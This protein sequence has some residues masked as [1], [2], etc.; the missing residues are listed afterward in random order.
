MCF[1]KKAFDIN[2]MGKIRNNVNPL[3]WIGSL[4][5][6]QGLPYV[7][8][9]T[10]SVIMYKRLGLSNT[11]I[12]FYTSWLYLPWVIKPLWSP[13]VELCSS[14]RIWIL[15]MQLIIGAA[16]ASI[17]LSLHTNNFFKWS[18]IIFWLIAF[19]SA[20]HDI[21]ADGF[22]ILALDSHKQALFVGLRSTF[23]RLSMIAGQGLLVM[24]A[25]YFE[26]NFG[27]G[28]F[29][30]TVESEKPKLS[31]IE[32]EKDSTFFLS[33]PN[34]TLDRSTDKINFTFFP[35]AKISIPNI[36]IP[37]KKFS[38]ILDEVKKFNSSESANSSHHNLIKEKKEN[39]LKTFIESF[40]KKFF[41]EKKRDIIKDTDNDLIGNVGVLFVTLNSKLDGEKKIVVNFD[42]KS[43]D[44]SIRLI[45]GQRHEFTSQNY[46]KPHVLL[47]QLDPN[48]KGATSA[49]FSLRFGNIKFAWTIIFIILSILFLLFFIYHFFLLPRPLNDISS[50]IS[51]SKI[52]S[53]FFSPFLSF[54]KKDN[55]LP[56]IAFLLLYRLGESQLVKLASPFLLDTKTSGGLSLSTGTLG[57]VYGTMGVFLLTVGGILGGIVV[58]RSGLK[59]W[60]FPM[61]IAINLPNI[62]YVYMAYYQPENVALI[63]AL[64]GIEQF[65][66]GFGFAAYMLFMVYYA[67]NSDFKTSHYAIMTGFMALGMMLPGM[68][69]GWLQEL[70]GYKNFFIWVC[71]STIPG[72]LIIPFLNIAPEFG[73]KTEKDK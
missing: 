4:Y 37:K 60:I 1:I 36:K 26:T 47:F 2:Y 61:T 28:E 30:L 5:F 38:E 33:P 17:A 29:E 52:L 71:I 3:L 39:S 63:T 53:N 64:V 18:L 45:E 35:S 55:I 27:G 54:F 58:A 73:I 7:A 6:A 23:Y 46:Y 8:V 32:Q 21:A 51:F 59:K 62:V 25:G 66:Y 31:A 14:R 42:F 10:L 68:W 22:Y 49:T 12:A 11:E 72:F 57:F 20:T 16:F 56:A 44:K 67:G 41:A 9:M 15:L 24:L 13:L 43:G 50:K 65:G 19:N 69:S 48:L 70:I 34:L 40:I